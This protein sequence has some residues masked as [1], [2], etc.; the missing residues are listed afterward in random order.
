MNHSTHRKCADS[1]LEHTPAWGYFTA[2]YNTLPKDRHIQFRGRH[3]VFHCYSCINLCTGSER[4]GCNMQ[5]SSVSW[6]KFSGWLLSVAAVNDKVWQNDRNRG[7]NRWRERAKEYLLLKTI[8]SRN[9]LAT[10]L[11]HHRGIYITTISIMA[12]VISIVII[13]IIVTIHKGIICHVSNS[14]YDMSPWT[15]SGQI[16]PL[17]YT[18]VFIS[19]H[20][21]EFVCTRARFC[22]HWI[23]F[24]IIH[25]CSYVV[26]PQQ[27]S[28]CWWRGRTERGMHW[29][30]VV[31]AKGCKRVLCGA[32]LDWASLCLGW[33][34]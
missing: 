15:D 6:W 17:Y 27:L 32:A 2:L 1:T 3:R 7:W 25:G 5:M 14:S 12:I 30:R 24:S 18:S 19:V 26:A 33:C 8:W 4:M 13:V 29:S 10:A 22:W 20:M 28:S 16:T 31:K 21:V 9:I 11:D 34:L 23:I